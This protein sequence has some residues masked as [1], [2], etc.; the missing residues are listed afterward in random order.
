MSWLINALNTEGRG[1]EGLELNFFKGEPKIQSN[2]FYC[3]PKGN[4]MIFL[5]LIIF[6]YE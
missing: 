3:D 2:Y 4:T 6:V 1:S 5:Y